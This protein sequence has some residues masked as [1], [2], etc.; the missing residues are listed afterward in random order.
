MLQRA[1]PW[2]LVWPYRSGSRGMPGRRLNWL[3]VV[4]AT[5][6]TTASVNVGTVPPAYPYTRAEA[7][8]LWQQWR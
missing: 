6:Q 8:N 7:W 5:S 1:T 4:P 2:G 3:T